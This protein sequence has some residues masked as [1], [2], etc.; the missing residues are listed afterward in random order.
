MV[1]RSLTAFGIDDL[2]WYERSNRYSLEHLEIIQN[3]MKYRNMT[4][5]RV[6]NLRSRVNKRITQLHQMRELLLDYLQFEPFRQWFFDN[7]ER[8]DIFQEVVAHGSSPLDEGELVKL[9]TEHGIE[10]LGAFRED[11][12]TLIIGQEGWDPEEVLKQLDLRTG[13]GIKVYSQEL[14]LTFLA[15]GKDPLNC[16]TSLL[17]Y[18]SSNHLG[19][20][21]LQNIGFPW[22]STNVLPGLGNLGDLEEPGWPKVG[23]L[24]YIGYHVGRSGN[25]SRQ[26]QEILGGI[27]RDED[28]PRVYSPQYMAEWGSARSSTR[29]RKMAESIASFA[30]LKKRQDLVKFARA[31][32]DWEADLEWLKQNFYTGRFSFRW[33]STIE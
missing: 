31:I 24:S 12:D 33:P 21:F 5:P 2:E 22:P 32:N 4:Y 3:E 27:F 23:L 6:W 7:S 10:Y 26:R 9:F 13:K 17:S 16:N 18:F 28:L 25:P 15:C 1:S 8:D 11:V 19:L 29:L 14:A 30:R 20:K